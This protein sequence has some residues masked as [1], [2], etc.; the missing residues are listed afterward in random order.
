MVCPIGPK[1]RPT[2]EGLTLHDHVPLTIGKAASGTLLVIM[3]SRTDGLRR[4]VL[5]CGA[6]LHGCLQP[7]PALD[8]G[9]A[10]TPRLAAGEIAPCR[11]TVAVGSPRD[12]LVALLVADY[13]HFARRLSVRLG[14]T[15]LAN[16]AL[17]DTYLRLSRAD[18]VEAVRHPAAYLFR[19]AINIAHNRARAESRHLSAS[20]V[21]ALLD[22]PDETPDPL[23][24]VEARFELAAVER[25]LETM[26]PRRRAMFRRFW[27]DNAT[28]HEIAIG[29][30]LS[31]RTVRHEL[32][33]ATRYLHRVTTEFQAIALPDRRAEVS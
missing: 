31:E 23:R 24:T 25:A 12:T 22:L 9:G 21:D 29:F 14:S 1:H 15:D 8:P 30:A 7:D 4:I 28:Y 17:Q 13:P 11:D 2:A 16:E 33:L 18:I 20:E 6:N 27:V 5:R 3:L 32:L 19:M 26:A 10:V